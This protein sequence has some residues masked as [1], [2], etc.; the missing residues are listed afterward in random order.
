MSTGTNVSLGD[1]ANHPDLVTVF[2]EPAREELAL[3]ERQ[4]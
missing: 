3:Y 1:D 2:A 4:S